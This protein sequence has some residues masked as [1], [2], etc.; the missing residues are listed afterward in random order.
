MIAL[1]YL[2]SNLPLLLDEIIGFL[3]LLMHFLLL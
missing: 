3:A 2:Y 1:L